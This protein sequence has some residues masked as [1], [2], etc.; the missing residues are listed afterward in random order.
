VTGEEVLKALAALV[1]ALATVGGAILW[2]AR[3][4]AGQVVAA[5]MAEIDRRLDEGQRE[6]AGLR[7]EVA[8]LRGAAR[9]TLAAV[10]RLLH[11]LEGGRR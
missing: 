2:I 7:A 4:A 8:E 3:L 5:Q 1:T 11:A 10:D 9:P 6:I